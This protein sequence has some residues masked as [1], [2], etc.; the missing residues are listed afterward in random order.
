MNRHD[1]D[2]VAAAL[3]VFDV[4]LADMPPTFE[5]RITAMRAALDAADKVRQHVAM[6]ETCFTPWPIDNAPTVCPVCTKGA[7]N[8]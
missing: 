4:T 6:C 3:I 8:D 5:N 2:R 1:S 7:V